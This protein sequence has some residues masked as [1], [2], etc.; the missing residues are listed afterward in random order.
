MNR[1]ALPLFLSLILTL[2][3]PLA[4]TAEN[5]IITPPGPQLDL[6]FSPAVLTDDLLFLSGAIGNTP[7]TTVV[8]GDAKAQTKRTMEN[9]G[10]VLKT[11][12][13]DFSRVVSST[14]FLADIRHFEAMNEVYG[15]YFDDDRPPTRATVEADIAIPN[16]QMEI[17]LIA[18]RKDVEL[19]W[20][21][22]EGWAK[23]PLYAWGVRAGDT[24]FVSGLVSFDPQTRQLVPGD[25]ATQAKRTLEN[26]DA[27]LEAGGMSKE[28]VVRCAVYL[29]DPRDYTMMNEVYGAYFDE[30]PPARA[31]V[32]ARL[33]DPSLTIEIQ[34]TAVR[35]ARKVVLPA[36][37]SPSP[38]PLSSAIQ[39]GD[40]LYLSG[41]VGRDG[42][43]YPAG[44][45]AQT[46]ITLERLEATLKAAGM[47]FEDVVSATV[48]LKDVRHYQAMNAVYAATLPDPPPARATVGMSLMSPEALVEIQMTAVRKE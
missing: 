39:V 22:P 33:A 35:G 15:A 8:E 7:G 28:N 32:R 16:S 42:G 2:A 43:A 4:G 29:A 31:T 10:D 48:F 19:E 34:C 11:A 9:L 12:G 6:P 46:K 20:V 40:R 27:V 30:A 17:S 1:S 41:M 21:V 13:L 14:V 37:A 36:G 44:V 38:R 24:L 26:I 47:S 45:A 23:S 18:A 3:F 5:K 25:L